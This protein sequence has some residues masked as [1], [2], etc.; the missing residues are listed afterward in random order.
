MLDDISG[1]RRQPNAARFAPDSP[2]NLVFIADL[3]RAG[4]LSDDE[5]SIAHL[6][7]GTT[8]PGG[9]FFPEADASQSEFGQFFLD[10]SAQAIFL[11][12]PALLTT[13]WKHPQPIAL[14]PNQQ[15]LS[16]LHRDEL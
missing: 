4:C 8:I 15:N 10:F 12:L 9:D 13:A 7:T 14:P 3:Q 1:S 5:D 2:I 6:S 11:G 16:T